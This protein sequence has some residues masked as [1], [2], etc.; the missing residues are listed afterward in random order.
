M[1]NKLYK[2]DYLVGL[3]IHGYSWSF[4]IMLP[5]ALLFSFDISF[6]FCVVMIVNGI[7]HSIVD[8][9]KA[10]EHK[11]NLIIDQ[12]IHMIQIVVTAIILL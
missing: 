6:D 9:A 7:I 10:N 3:I 4:M 11:I 12:T 1:P 5:I 2:Y 8:D